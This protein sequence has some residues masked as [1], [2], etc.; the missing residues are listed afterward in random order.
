[1]SSQHRAFVA[2]AGRPRPRASTLAAASRRAS[3]RLR[4]SKTVLRRLRSSPRS[5]Q[6]RSFRRGNG[7]VDT[8]AVTA[9]TARSSSWLLP[10]TGRRGSTRR[11]TGR[12]LAIAE[13]PRCERPTR[14]LQCRRAAG[15]DG[16]PRSGRLGMWTG[17][18]GIRARALR[19]DAAGV[20]DAGVVAG[21]SASR[22]DDGGRRDRSAVARRHRQARMGTFADPGA[23]RRS[24]TSQRRPLVA[25]VRRRPARTGLRRCC[26][27]G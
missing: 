9:R 17:T 7:V 25:V 26:G 13:A 24:S 27:G 6:A 5:V 18:G 14:L 8:A 20:R 11:R 3:I 16:E 22:R 2:T 4:R 1:M 12:S 21:R 19:H 15:R 10:R 23:A